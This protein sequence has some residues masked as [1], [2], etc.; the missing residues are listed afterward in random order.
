MEIQCKWVV[1]YLVIQLQFSGISQKNDF[2]ARITS[3]ERAQQMSISLAL[4]NAILNQ[5]TSQ[6]RCILY[7]AIYT[8]S[9]LRIRQAKASSEA[10]REANSPRSAGVCWLAGFNMASNLRASVPKCQLAR[11]FFRSLFTFFFRLLSIHKNAVVQTWFSK[12][13]L[14]TYVVI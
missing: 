7:L 1:F 9:T 5:H 11:Q 8:V 14:G 2:S 6:S 10:S 12:Y 13:L 3:W 4:P